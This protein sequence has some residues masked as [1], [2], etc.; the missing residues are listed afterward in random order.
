[1]PTKSKS[2][3][4]PPFTLPLGK[5]RRLTILLVI[6][7]ILS[8]LLLVVVQQDKGRAANLIATVQ[9]VQGESD[10]IPDV[11]TVVPTPTPSD[12]PTPTPTASSSSPTPTPSTTSTPTPTPTATESP[13]PTAAAQ[14]EYWVTFGPGGIVPSNIDTASKLLA[15]LDQSEAPFPTGFT[16]EIARWANNA[17]ESHLYGNQKYDFPIQVGE[18]YVVKFPYQPSLP[19]ASGITYSDPRS[20]SYQLIPGWNLISLPS[21]V[22][23]GIPKT[24]AEGMCMGILLQGGAATM[25]GTHSD[26]TGV[27]SSNWKYHNCSTQDNDFTLVS[28]KAYFVRSDSYSTWT[29]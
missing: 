27:G 6:L 22:L 10:E 11:D 4:T 7:L 2:A 21:S 18:G 17:W 20:M 14:N 1:M 13:T 9:D 8:T 12:T 15:Y 29:P 25:V 19:L 26:S 16:F 23:G 3:A 5:P 28:G 24:S